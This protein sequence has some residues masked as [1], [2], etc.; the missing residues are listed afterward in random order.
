M[1]D[2]VLKKNFLVNLFFNLHLTKCVAYQPARGYVAVRDHQKKF[3]K[4]SL[5]LL[6]RNIK[7]FNLF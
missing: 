7:N 1:T 3:K 4:L 2:D 6:F 5:P